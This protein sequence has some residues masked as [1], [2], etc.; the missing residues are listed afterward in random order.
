MFIF[1]GCSFTYGQGLQYYWLVENTDKTWGD[2][3]DYTGAKISQER[4]SFGADQYRIHHSYPHLVSKHF[5]VNYFNTS[6]SNGGSN[7]GMWNKLRKMHAFCNHSHVDYHIIQFTNPA[8]DLDHDRYTNEPS[9][10]EGIEELCRSQ[11]EKIKVEV[12]TWPDNKWLGL[13]WF[14]EIGKIL[15][16]EFPDNFIPIIHKGEEYIS[17]EHLHE[18]NI[19]YQHPES[20]D[21]HFSDYGHSVIAESIIKK[22]E[23]SPPT[24]IIKIGDKND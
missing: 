8:R 12:S 9:K 13:S 15:K 21:R 1:Y 24:K 7:E 20:S 3:N 16:E 10:I 2:M 11:I 19:N 4:L 18:L 5:D 14:N 17:F 22:V 6:I 23:E